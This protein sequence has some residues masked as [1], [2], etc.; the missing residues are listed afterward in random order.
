MKICLFRRFILEDGY[1]EVTSEITGLH[2]SVIL[3]LQFI[4][5]EH[6]HSTAQLVRMLGYCHCYQWS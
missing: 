3:S 4:T 1:V 2:R 6:T 5:A